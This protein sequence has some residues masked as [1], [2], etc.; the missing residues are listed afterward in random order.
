MDLTELIRIIVLAVEKYFFLE[1]QKVLA[2]Y[3]DQANRHELAEAAQSIN[4]RADCFS[5][6]DIERVTGE[7]DALFVDYI[8]VNMVAEAALGLCISPWGRLAA[9]MFSKN[10]PVF[11]L[12]KDPDS[13]VFSQAC[14]ALLKEHWARLSSLGV[15]LLDTGRGEAQVPA[16][17]ETVFTGNVFS[18]KDI[19]RYCGVNK[20]IVGKN[21]LITALAEETARELGIMLARQK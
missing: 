9:S 6:V 8:P 18:R 15:V 13:G 7:Y 14:R 2:L 16:Q 11:Q 1:R 12:K 4:G 21:V 19:F 17:N 3:F 10:K 20:I 5:A